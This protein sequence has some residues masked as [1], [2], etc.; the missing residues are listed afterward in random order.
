MIQYANYY[1]LNYPFLKSNTSP[2]ECTKL[3]LLVLT[4]MKCQLRCLQRCNDDKIM[5]LTIA[6]MNSHINRYFSNMPIKITF[7]EFIKNQEAFIEFEKTDFHD[8]L[9]FIVQSKISKYF[10]YVTKI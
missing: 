10:V 9:P 6:N 3:G 7:D 4:N 8:Q 2:L 1:L 5:Q